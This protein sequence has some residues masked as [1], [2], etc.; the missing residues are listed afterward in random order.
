MPS[1]A[2]ASLAGAL[3]VGEAYRKTASGRTSGDIQ[4]SLVGGRQRIVDFEQLDSP[5]QFRI[6]R[7]QQYAP[8]VQ[9]F[10]RR[11]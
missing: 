11:S 6:E 1:L 3:M 7:S 2:G 8:V 5:E 10:S 9:G 4:Q